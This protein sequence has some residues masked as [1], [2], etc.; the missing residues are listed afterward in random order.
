MSEEILVIFNALLY[1]GLL[2]YYW[3]KSRQFNLGVYLL[4]LWAICAVAGCLYEPFN[5][6]YGHYWKITLWPY[7]YLFVCNVMMFVPILSFKTD[8]IEYVAVNVA[9]L[10]YVAIF[11]GLISILPFIESF[12][13]Y[14]HSYGNQKLLLDAF[15]ERYADP[16]TTYY[17]LST[18]SRRLTY[19]LHA[20][21][22]L[23]LFLL[24][25]LPVISNRI[26]YF[27]IVYAG[28]LLSVVMI[29]LESL[30]LLARFQ[31]II[32]ALFGFFIFMT[33]KNMYS[34]ALRQRA[35]KVLFICGSALLIV[36]IAQTISRYVNYTTNLTNNK[37]AGWVYLAQYVGE[38]MGNFNANIVHSDHYFGIEPILRTYSNLFGIEISQ[39]RY[40][41]TRFFANQFFTVVGEFWRAYGGVA[42]FVIFLITSSL[43]YVYVK[44][45]VKP[46]I[47]FFTLMLFFMYSKLAIVGIFYH[48]YF[49][50]V[51]ELLVLPVLMIFLSKIKI[52]VPS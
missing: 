16:K 15:N 5:V 41:E 39:S 18:I 37:V 11:I 24:F 1:L 50:D 52:R 25:Y 27:K 36:E 38:S 22:T 2:W 31:V 44:K 8:R 12:I 42:T 21:R 26:R 19:I 46:H 43:M 13:H 29:M 9:L 28:V 3:R 4:S 14:L 6:I 32:Y 33:V 51:D 7:I 45:Y 20:T 49:V 40:Y 34:D 17:Y 23:S 48:A 30:I 47:S 10:R 35:K